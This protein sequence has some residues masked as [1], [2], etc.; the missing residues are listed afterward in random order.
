M[1]LRF[2]TGCAAA[3]L[4]L[5]LP[6]LL[7]A[8]ECDPTPREVR[9]NRPVRF[10]IRADVFEFQPSRYDW[11]TLGNESLVT[12]LNKNQMPFESYIRGNYWFWI[13]DPL[14]Y[15]TR[16]DNSLVWEYD[17]NGAAGLCFP[18][19]II[20]DPEAPRL[21][22]TPTSANELDSGSSAHP[23]NTSN[24][25]TTHEEPGVLAFP[26]RVPL[27][28]DLSYRSGLFCDGHVA[29]TLGNGW[30]HNYDPYM[31]RYG[32]TLTPDGPDDFAELD[33]ARVVLDQGRVL[34]FAH[35]GMGWQ[36]TGNAE[37]PYQLVMD[38]TDGIV[39][40]PGSGLHH[41]FRND[42]AGNDGRLVSIGDRWGNQLTLNWNPALDNQRLE[43]VSD[44]RGNTLTFNY[45]SFE[46]LDSVSDGTRTV[47]FAVD[48]DRQLLSIGDPRNPAWQNQF[49]YFSTRFPEV[50]GPS[51]PLCG[52]GFGN[53]AAL[54]KSLVR[55]LGNNPYSF[56]FNDHGRCTAQVD[57][58]G[59]QTTFGYNGMTTV[60]LPD[61][62]T[63]THQHDAWGQLTGVVDEAGMGWGASFDANGNR[64]GASSPGGGSSSFTTHAPS[65]HPASVTDA[66]GFTTSFSYTE[67]L[68][69]LGLRYHYLDEVDL[70]DGS[71]EDYDF[72]ADGFLSSFTDRN[73]GLW[74]FTFTT[75][76]LLETMT[77]PLGGTTTWGYDPT[78]RLPT[79]VEDPSGN[80]TTFT[81]DALGNPWMVN[82]ADGNSWTFDHDAL[83][84]V[85]SFE[86]E[87]GHS[88]GI[89][90][91]ANGN[92][93]EV[94]FPGG[95][96]V[97][98]K[99]DLMDR[100]VARDGPNNPDPVNA[101]TSGL[102]QSYDSRG[103]TVGI[104]YRIGTSYG[105]G[106]DVRGGLESVTDAFNE[107]W[108]LGHDERGNPD[109]QTDPLGNTTTLMFDANDRL[110]GSWSPLGFER[111]YA[112]DEVGNLTEAVNENGESTTYDW[113]GANRLSWID[114]GQLGLTLAIDYNA[115]GQVDSITDGAGGRTEVDH[116]A[117][118]R[119]VAQ[120][121]PN[122]R[123]TSF[124]YNNRNR[125]DMVLYP[126]GL[127]SQTLVYDGRG[128]LTNRDYSDG[129]SYAYEFDADGRPSG[130]TGATIT[131]DADGFVVESNGITCLRE[132]NTGLV[133]T[134]TVGP[135]M[136]VNYTYNL[137]GQVETVTDWT[138]FT[139]TYDYLANGLPDTITRSNGI[140]TDHDWDADSRLARLQHVN[141]S[142][143]FDSQITRDGVGNIT[144]VD[145][146]APLDYD[147]GASH[148]GVRSFDAA[149]QDQAHPFDARGNLQSDGTY[150]YDWNLA[151][152]LNGYTNNLD[153]TV[154][155]EWDGWGQMIGRTVNG[156]E[157]RFRTFYGFENPCQVVS[158]D[159]LGVG[160]HYVIPDPSGQPLGFVD[161]ATGEHFSLHFDESGNTAAVSDEAG[162]LRAAFAY[163]PF[164]LRQSTGDKADI[165]WT[166]GAQ[167][168]YFSESDELYLASGRLYHAR[169]QR[170][171]QPN[172]H[173]AYNSPY[174]FRGFN[175]GDVFPDP[176]ESA[177]YAYAGG[178]PVNRLHGPAAG[179]T[180]IDFTT[181]I[182]GKR[183]R[184]AWADD[185]FGL[186]QELFSPGGG[187]TLRLALNG[188]RPPGETVTDVG[189]F[190]KGMDRTG[191]PGELWLTNY[192]AGSPVEYGAITDGF[193]IGA[194][195]VN[196]RGLGVRLQGSWDRYVRWD[197]ARADDELRELAWLKE[198]GWISAGSYSSR[199]RE[200][201]RRLRGGMNPVTRHGYAPQVIRPATELSG[202]PFSQGRTLGIDAIFTF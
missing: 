128:N 109:E 186:A 175:F 193:P 19:Y 86:D 4:V 183:S 112:Y 67:Q 53:S 180:S 43:S 202:F 30:T 199:V 125:V 147:F 50:G 89:T 78:T 116:D 135:S 100:I 184:A 159:A 192:A 73:G 122:G 81:H 42:E 146:N 120:R 11:L 111:H 98:Y 164:G 49:T 162:A 134:L 32:S 13:G 71:S 68:D 161:G 127:G 75:D 201:H 138:G 179:R 74:A 35:D 36:L 64:D 56:Q 7:S 166:F 16:V 105:L 8:H 6:A 65:G 148:L 72:D 47:D 39:L 83:G 52:A 69:S 195:D 34:E 140:T 80:L 58:F 37:T 142:T 171:I 136:D 168:N 170:F 17:P 190:Y 76:N 102:Q 104:G 145:R 174:A 87:D 25:E 167:A 51:A 197:Q 187:P 99:F 103:F 18:D 55:P 84:N 96:I 90:H 28:L 189:R 85:T 151:G 2:P 194:E 97:S 48:F 15:P 177:P 88:H 143:L 44:G 157:T 169:G 9:P 173:W 33:R 133:L 165:P 156:E 29:S 108:N 178:N 141:G 95:D 200:L 23:V 79:S 26:G 126:G 20:V 22:P 10:Q 93:S 154:G 176:V 77:N 62:S 107:T 101:P 41:R 185:G 191:G 130:T 61:T 82:F 114:R 31:K 60:T 160:L 153:L 150:D 57:A 3:A 92:R 106:Y 66:L 129:T 131:T 91:D 63:Y 132:P 163:S 124:W 118:G 172:R 59:N 38:G 182:S 110:A 14:A 121:D 158:E 94:L 196:F 181:L 188:E 137:R 70:P 27:S 21:T 152:Q 198:K 113:V 46:Q 139:Y 123:E 12:L 1:F 119:R 24:G 45:V 5:L 155:Y 117:Q 144:M 149:S 40:D 54:L 115:L